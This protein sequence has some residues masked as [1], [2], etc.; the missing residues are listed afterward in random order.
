MNIFKKFNPK[1]FDLFVFDSN[2]WKDKN[3]KEVKNWKQKMIANW[4]RETKGKE[5]SDDGRAN[6]VR[7]IPRSSTNI[8]TKL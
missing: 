1:D 2:N 7:G 6:R 5:M 4:E 3:G 8:G